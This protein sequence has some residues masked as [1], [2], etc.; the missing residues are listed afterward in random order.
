MAYFTKSWLVQAL[1]RFPTSEGSINI[2][3]YSK[4]SILL[5][6]DNSDFLMHLTSLAVLCSVVQGCLNCVASVFLDVLRFPHTLRRFFFI[7]YL[8]FDFSSGCV[9]THVPL[10]GISM[11]SL[12]GSGHHKT[13]QVAGLSSVTAVS[14]DW[15]SVR[16]PVS[17]L[18]FSESLQLRVAT[19]FVCPV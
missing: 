3:Y 8:V 18:L 16:G 15:G 10:E 14:K 11:E 1:V 5:H 6:T 19:L 13:R 9:N 2:S 12:S 4:S 7:S 17:S